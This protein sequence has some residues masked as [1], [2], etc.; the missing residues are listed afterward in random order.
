M[1]TNNDLSKLISEYFDQNEN[2]IIFYDKTNQIE[3]RQA[4]KIIKNITNNLYKYSKIK[5]KK[6]IIGILL[7]RNVY[8]LLS[9]FACWELGATI[10]PL[11]KTWPK[12]HLNQIQKKLNFDY[13][14]TDNKNYY[15]KKP[16]IPLKSIL[17]K[18]SDIRLN[19]KLSILRKQNVS[20]YIIFTSGS[21]GFQKGVEIT[22]Q[23]YLDYIKWTKNNFKKFKNLS[24]LIITAEMTFDITMG[25]LAFALAHKTS[26]VISSSTKNFF[27][28]LNLINKYKVEVFYSVPT[29]INL[30]L[31][32][33][34]INNEIKT[35]KLFI[36]GGDIFNLSMIDKIVKNNPKAAFYNVYGPTECTIN[37]TSIRLDNLYRK[38]KISRIS[39][40]KVFK[41]L[42][43]KLIVFKN[44]N[45]R[46]SN[47]Y[48]ELI[49][50]GSQVMRD[51]INKEDAKNNYFL[52][53]KDEKFYRTGDLVKLENK[54]LYLKGRVDDLVKIRGYRINPQE[55]DNIISNNK[56][57]VLSKTLVENKR[58]RLITFIQKK[59]KTNLTE[60]N[61]FIKKNLPS[62]M[63]PS[64]IILI[65]KFPIGKSGKIDKKKLVKS[66]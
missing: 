35:V 24:P 27:E 46:F 59:T 57:I 47:N 55:V 3:I 52:H 66:I 54:L 14:I 51:Y 33:S 16:F 45:L 25:D 60:I 41:H 19:N 15:N 49:I 53:I 20:P 7:D 29:T 26:I 12:N 4:K 9:I 50:S 56:K 43:Y 23:G 58:N 48:G 63:V 61:N 44:N 8:Y 34:K 21:S 22:S 28:H 40:G 18:N 36:S 64:K 62:Y 30:I 31:D 17:K 39:I 42:K 37:V 2:K 1:K 13:I 5:K 38:N 32:Y 10:V 6:L 65:N 11:N